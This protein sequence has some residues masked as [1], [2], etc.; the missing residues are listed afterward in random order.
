VRSPEGKIGTIERVVHTQWGPLAY[1][2]NHDPKICYSLT[3]LDLASPEEIAIA[4][5]YDAST[6]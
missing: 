5:V 1:L 2:S 3:D 6:S 4:A